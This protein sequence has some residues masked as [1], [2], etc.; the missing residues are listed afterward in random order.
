MSSGFLH[1]FN[2]PPMSL[3][4]LSNS[5][6]KL[7]NYNKFIKWHIFIHK[8]LWGLVN[9]AYIFHLFMPEII[10]VFSCST[11]FTMSTF[12]YETYSPLNNIPFLTTCAPFEIFNT[13]F[14][15]I[16]HTP[17]LIKSSQREKISFKFLGVPLDNTLSH[18]PYILI[19][20]FF[21]PCMSAYFPS[22]ILSPMI[23]QQVNETNQLLS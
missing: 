5:I 10:Q 17:I 9:S 20:I 1:W 7:S 23:E 16:V 18:T 19:L 12:T 13:P 14:Q 15:E 21:N 8:G 11:F 6:L 4:L 2:Y 3:H 22:K